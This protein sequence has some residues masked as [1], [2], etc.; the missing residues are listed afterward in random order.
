MELL[1]PHLWA[2]ASR[3]CCPSP[4]AWLHRPA[5]HKQPEARAQQG[6]QPQ[7]PWQGCHVVVKRLGAGARPCSGPPAWRESPTSASHSFHPG[8]AVGGGSSFSCLA[9]VGPCIKQV[10]SRHSPCPCAACPEVSTQP[11]ILASKALLYRVNW[12]FLLLFLEQGV[13]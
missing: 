12:G 9:R 2:H 7:L 5:A 10:P 11:L 6:N 3:H 1:L 4:Q 13:A 8:M